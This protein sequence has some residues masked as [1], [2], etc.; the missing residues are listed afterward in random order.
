MQAEDVLG[1]MVPATYGF[2]AITEKLSPARR[3]P[4]MRLWNLLGVVFLIVLGTA[5]TV[6]PLLVPVDWLAAH[7]LVDGSRLGVVGGVLVG[8]PLLALVAMAYHRT[9]HKV[10]FLW[11]WTHQMHHAPQRLDMPGAVFFHPFDMIFQIVIQLAMVTVVLGLDP[12]AAAITGYVAAFYGMFQHWNVR[13][14]RWIGFLIQRPES[15][16]AHHERDVHARNYS[17]FPVWDILFGTFYNP[18]TFEG[19]VGFDEQASIAL[20]L[21]GRDVNEASEPREPDGLGVG[22]RP[23]HR[24][25]A[26]PAVAR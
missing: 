5:S 10:P 13:T 26:P 14:P 1:L 4:K 19:E 23:T 9:I 8:Y 17:D 3:F 20:M 11:R 7:R 2:F 18:E 24:G 6:L 12:L 25:E 22:P 16:C 15:H 21:A